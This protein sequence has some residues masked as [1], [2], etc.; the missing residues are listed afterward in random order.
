MTFPVDTNDPPEV[1]QGAVVPG[2]GR[3]GL[4][5]A[6]RRY[7]RSWAGD[8]G[9]ELKELQFFDWTMVFGAEL[10]WSALPLFIILSSLADHRVD[11]DI[12]RHIGLDR[13]G[14]HI[15][16][17]L[18]RSTPSHA[19]LAILTGALFSLTGVLSVIA[20]LQVMYERLFRQQ[21]RGWRDLPRYLVWILTLAAILTLEASLDH[22]E[23]NAGGPVLQTLVT[24][25]VTVVFF[26]WTMHFLLA[27]RVP[28]RDLVRPTLISAVLWIAFGFFSSLYFSSTVI[29]DSKTYGTIGVVFTLLTWFIVIGYVIVLGAAAGAVWQRRSSGSS[30]QLE[31]T[32]GRT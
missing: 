20:S 6:Q 23:R 5:A 2:R 14:A 24:F 30:E 27:G 29:D 17:T 31:N 28:W 25:V 16:S 8:L 10:L 13:Q 3:R 32:S 12:S 11:G 18:F 19:V 9:S 15:V 26:L 7:E 22:A 1:S 4:E 21:A